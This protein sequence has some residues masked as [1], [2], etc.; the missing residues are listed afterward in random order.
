MATPIFTD[1]HVD[2]AER[3]RS[4]PSVPI[5]IMP[6][7]VVERRP[8][9]FDE[10]SRRLPSFIDGQSLSPS[11]RR[12]MSN[13]SI[14]S[15]DDL[16]YVVGH[17]AKIERTASRRAATFFS[18]LHSLHNGDGRAPVFLSVSRDSEAFTL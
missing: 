14:S 6:A 17:A 5:R 4:W 9:S 7:V 18:E 15:L 1:S 11:S 8:C 13:D 10:S 16:E 2:E 12:R 3:L